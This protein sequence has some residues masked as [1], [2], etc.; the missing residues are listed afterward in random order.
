MI[1]YPSYIL[2]IVVIVIRIVSAL[3][4][5]HPIITWVFMEVSLVALLPFISSSS[6]VR[7]FVVQAVR[8]IIFFLGVLVVD[9]SLFY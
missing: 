7:Y 4:T 3:W 8:S 5:D 6:G 9:I 2:F 1:R